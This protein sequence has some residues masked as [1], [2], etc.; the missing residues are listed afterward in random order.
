M[1]LHMKKYSVRWLRAMLLAAMF[2][3]TAQ[4]ASAHNM[5]GFSGSHFS[6]HNVAFHH[7]GDHFSHHDGNHF[8]HHDGD[9]FFDHHHHFFRDRFFFFGF[10]YP[11]YGYPYDYPYDSGY[12]DY[13]EAPYGDQYWSELT[14]AVQTELARDGYYRGAIDGVFGPDTGR[15]IRAYRRAKGLPVTDQIDRNLLMSLNI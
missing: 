6:G 10:G 4:A 14:T 7:D 13:S 5:G 3:F 8:F 12:Y 1:P 9:H 2:L 15:A 11:F